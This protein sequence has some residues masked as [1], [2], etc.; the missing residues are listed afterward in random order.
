[1]KHNN[2]L[3]MQVT[4]TKQLPHWKR[5]TLM[6]RT[7]D[8]NNIDNNTKNKEKK[9]QKK[10]TK[11]N[12]KNDLTLRNGLKNIPLQMKLSHWKPMTWQ[13]RRNWN[14][15]TRKKIKKKILNPPLPQWIGTPIPETQNKNETQ[16]PKEL[17]NH[18]KKKKKPDDGNV[19]KKRTDMNEPPN[20]PPQKKKKKKKKKKNKEKRKPHHPKK[21]KPKILILH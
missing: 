14:K 3:K 5:T 17:E 4:H 12:G 20:Q 13:M 16:L 2:T 1:M 18:L 9:P 6:K 11:K 19:E 15:K 7:K 8:E 10:P 21:K